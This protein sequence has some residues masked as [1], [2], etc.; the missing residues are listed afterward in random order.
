MI[1]IQWQFPL[2]FLLIL[3]EPASIGADGWEHLYQRLTTSDPA[4]VMWQDAGIESIL[5]LEG[6]FGQN[7][8][9]NPAVHALGLAMQVKARR[10]LHVGMHGHTSKERGG[11]EGLHAWGS[12]T[13]LQASSAI[14]RR[15][16]PFEVRF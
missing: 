1:P 15:A 10:I 5:A 3:I 7:L 2:L 4:S 16:L 8:S 14:G 9:C 12:L 6:I 11:L 13:G